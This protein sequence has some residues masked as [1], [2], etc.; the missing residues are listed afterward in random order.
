L[1]LLTFYKNLW[2]QVGVELLLRLISMFLQN[3]S[4]RFMKMTTRSCCAVLT[5][6]KQDLVEISSKM[7]PEKHF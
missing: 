4:I 5:V 2:D 3:A 7:T 1:L 6:I